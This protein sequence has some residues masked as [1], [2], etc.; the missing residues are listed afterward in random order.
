MGGSFAVGFAAFGKARTLAA[1]ATVAAISPIPTVP[2]GLPPTFAR[3]GRAAAVAT[4]I[5]LAATAFTGCILGR[6]ARL[7]AVGIAVGIA[8]GTGAAIRIVPGVG[9]AL[10]TG[11]L[12][13]SWSASFRSAA[14]AVRIVFGVVHSGAIGI[15]A[16]PRSSAAGTA[17]AWAFVHTTRCE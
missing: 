13:V 6:G 3:H 15:A 8:V 14:V 7:G 17:T 2:P 5:A 11:T 1:I 16:A 10:V 12:S 4:P 9:T